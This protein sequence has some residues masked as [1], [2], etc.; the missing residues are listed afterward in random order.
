MRV[1]ILISLLIILI[2][3]SATISYFIISSLSRNLLDNLEK[4]EEHI[5]LNQW[6]RARTV[7]KD[8]NKDWEKAS[9]IFSLVIDHEHLQDLK[10]TLTRISGLI[11]L[12]A[13]Y[14]LVVEIKIA[15]M[16]VRSIKQDEKPVLKNIF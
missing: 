4:L 12:E 16:L 3:T 11:P 15:K 13:R 1:L 7:N 8:I 2:I 5:I 9:S 6:S 14:E 10:I